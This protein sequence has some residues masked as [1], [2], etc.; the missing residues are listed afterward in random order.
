MTPV[1]IGPDGNFI[2]E[3]EDLA[4]SSSAPRAGY[5][6]PPPQLERTY[7]PTTPVAERRG[8]EDPYEQPEEPPQQR[9]P[10]RAIATDCTAYQ[11]PCKQIRRILQLL[12]HEK[13]RTR[14]S[15]LKGSA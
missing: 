11:G 1:T 3:P 8:D 10:L 12:K 6:H 13:V 14:F 4:T 15:R 5:E 9:G 7:A 2:P